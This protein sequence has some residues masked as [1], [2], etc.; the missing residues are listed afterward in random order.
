[1]RGRGVRLLTVVGPAGRR[2]L[3]L[4]GEASLVFLLPVLVDLVG[5]GGADRSSARWA[6]YTSDGTVLPRTRSLIA[7]G[8]AD[9]EVL[10]LSRSGAGST[11]LIAPGTGDDA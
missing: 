11:A 7:A 4:A 8:V 9:G 3:V 2:D 10:E 5:D 1:V 6:L